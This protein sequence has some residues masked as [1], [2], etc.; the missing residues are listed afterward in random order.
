MRKSIFLA[1]LFLALPS[2]LAAQA[3]PPFPTQPELGKWW[4]NSEMFKKLGLTKDQ[5]NRIEE[6]FL[7]NSQ[8]LAARNEEWKRLQGEWRELLNADPVNEA[9]IMAQNE[10]VSH[11]RTELDREYAA[12]MLAI[13]KILTKEQWEKLQN[14]GGSDFTTFA[15]DKKPPRVLYQPLPAYTQE[16]RDAKISGIVLLRAIIRKDGTV[17]SFKV[18]RGL[19]YGLDESAMHT[20]ATKWKFEPGTINGQPADIEVNIEVSFRLWDR[21]E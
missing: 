7:N 15:G 14:T 12:M 6:V 16:A 17:D 18:L 2:I 3:I 4:K 20:I 21:N 10:E 5:A 1:V 19:G 11:A 8:R 13:R 9:R